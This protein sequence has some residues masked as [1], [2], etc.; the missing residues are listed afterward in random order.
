MTALP[1]AWAP[2]LGL[3]KT[4]LQPILSA[5]GHSLAVNKER[6]EL[7]VARA[8][9]VAGALSVLILA[10]ILVDLA[11][12]ELET[13]LALAHGRLV[14]S[15]VFALIAVRPYPALNLG[16]AYQAL[17]LLFLV[18]V[19]FFGY[20]NTVFAA[21]PGP[22]PPL[23][24]TYVFFLFAV[25]AGVSLFP[26][27]IL[28]SVFMTVPLLA[29]MALAAFMPNGPLRDE[30]HLGTLWLL[31]LIAVI[32]GVAALAQLH[33]LIRVVDQ[34]TR[35]GLTG[36][37]TRRFALS[38]LSLTFPAAV[39]ADT[40][41]ALVFID[42][43]RFKAVN[44]RFGHEAGDAVLRNAAQA[45]LRVARSQDLVV[46]WGGEEFLVVLPG[47]DA[48]G[49]VRFIERLQT[50]GLGMRPDGTI[51]TASVGIAERSVDRAPTL[52]ALVDLADRRMYAAKTAGRN[53]WTDVGGAIH[54]FQP[55]RGAA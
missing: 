29:G 44:D 31:V 24:T 49:A 52:N 55:S 25:A 43:D 45:L 11:V 33:L 38:F 3:W 48:A 47:T 16:A 28:E 14:A 19:G 26:L 17:L 39:R 21:A 23:A 36:A 34:T 42:L 41:L 5:A 15:A 35:D 37:L 46:R 30:I 7:I 1:T 27:T 12:F 51:Q 50:A 2:A 40:K 53:R 9:L 4:R 22:L 8:R 18:L 10:W 20:V 54:L 6:T 32:G 13:A